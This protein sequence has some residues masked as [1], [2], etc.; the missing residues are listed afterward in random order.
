M[1]HTDWLKVCT[2]QGKQLSQMLDEDPALM[3]RRTQIA[4]RLELYRAARDEIDAVAWLKWVS[5][6][7]QPQGDSSSLGSNSLQCLN[8]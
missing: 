7:G 4:K 8:R 1:Q 3:E 2:M 6:L 5:G